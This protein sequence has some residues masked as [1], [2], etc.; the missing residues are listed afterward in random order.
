MPDTILSRLSQNHFSSQPVTTPLQTQVDGLVSGFVREAANPRTLASIAA[1]SMA[2]RL[3][4]LG[5]MGLGVQST[6]YF[7]TLARPLSIGLGLGA[8]VVA[9]E[10]SGRTRN[11]VRRSFEP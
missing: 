7:G 11:F 9:F 4:R 5:V 3:T 1:G 10:G 8:E 6:G 2:Y